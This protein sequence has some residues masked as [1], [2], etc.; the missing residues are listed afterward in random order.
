LESDSR[1]NLE[2]FSEMNYFVFVNGCTYLAAGGYSLWQGHAAWAVVW[3]SYGISAM[4][5]SVLE[6]RL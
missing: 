1:S 2:G 4:V 5:L 6:G 3:V